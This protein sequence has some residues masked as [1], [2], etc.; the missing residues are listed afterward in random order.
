MPLAMD[1]MSGV[2]SQ[3]SMQNILP[4]L[5]KPDITSSAMRRT[6]WSS[7]I[8]L[9]RGMYSST[10]TRIPLLPTM[11]SITTP[12][13]VFGPSI[14]MISSMISTQVT[15]QPGYSLPKGHL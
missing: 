11:G 12:A 7:H 2:T 3:C 1:M 9:S 10:G 13:T 4:V 14:R 5:P 8:S 6:S 15:P